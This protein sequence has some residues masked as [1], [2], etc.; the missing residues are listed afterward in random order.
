M[1]MLQR[2][3]L[4]L[5]GIALVFAL[6]P[7]LGFGGYA[8]VIPGTGIHPPRLSVLNESTLPF[9]ASLYRLMEAPLHLAG[10][11]PFIDDIVFFTGE[12]VVTVHPF[13]I[14][15]F[16]VITSIALTWVAVRPVLITTVYGR[17]NRDP[18]PDIVG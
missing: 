14:F 12:G 5:G 2:I 6:L 15:V 3:M 13:M 9:G 18:D 10:C 11:L 17:R 16:W 8:F 7:W 1:T 4:G